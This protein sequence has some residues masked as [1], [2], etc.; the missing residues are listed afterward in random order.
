MKEKITLSTIAEHLGVSTATVSLAL[1]DSSL[2]AGT[3]RDKI[4]AS[5]AELG[6]IYD[7]RAASLRTSRSGI[8]GVLMH[9][10]VNPFFAEILIAIEDEL[11]ASRRI[12]LLCNHRDNLNTQTNFINTLLQFGA[13]GVI[14]SPAIDTTL[15]DIEKIEN[16]GLPVVLVARDIPGA[17]VPVFRGNDKKGIQIA[18]QHLIDLGHRVIA[19]VGGRRETS[20]GRDRRDGY[21]AALQ[22]AGI[23][24]NPALQTGSQSTRQ[25]GY[26]CVRA[27]FESGQNPTGIVCFNDL[28]A[29]GVMNGLR[30]IGKEPGVDVSVT[31]YDNIAEAEIFSPAL[32]TVWNGQQ[33]VGKLAARAM[34]E[35][36]Q[37]N[38]P[39]KNHIYFEPEFVERNSTRRLK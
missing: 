14:I 15:E 6:Y 27:L 13:D 33:E 12:F 3:T 28:L 8:I 35:I 10:I 2:V 34:V 18:T 19:F 21:L 38:R 25:D 24:P 16:N 23:E 22:E 39:S 5:A 32:T 30:S 7:R 36:L 26:D 29:F 9:D 4:K 31:G 17:T 1:R 20:T 37:G 11:E